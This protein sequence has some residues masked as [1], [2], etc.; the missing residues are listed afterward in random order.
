[1][2]VITYGFQVDRSFTSKATDGKRLHDA[3]VNPVVHYRVKRYFEDNGPFSSREAPAPFPYMPVHWEPTRGT[4]K[5]P[6]PDCRRIIRPLGAFAVTDD[7]RVVASKA[8]RDQ[9]GHF[10]CVGRSRNAV[11][12]HEAT[13]AVAHL[14]PTSVRARVVL[15]GEERTRAS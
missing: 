15:A 7:P 13:A 10:Q 3:S 8:R 11:R 5:Y 14:R 9:Q 2:L 12:P 4:A 1:M 6:Y